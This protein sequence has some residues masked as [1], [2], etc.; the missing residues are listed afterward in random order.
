MYFDTITVGA[1]NGIMGGM[2]NVNYYKDIMSEKTIKL[3][4]K[5]LR[6]K[7]FPII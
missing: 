3:T 7:T 5:T 1:E 4:Y 6:E 2:C